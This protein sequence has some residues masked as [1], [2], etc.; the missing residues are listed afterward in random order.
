MDDKQNTEDQE[1]QTETSTSAKEDLN[2]TIKDLEYKWKRALADYHNLQKETAKEKAEFVKFANGALLMEILPVYEN[3]KTSLEHADENNHDAWLKGIKHVVKQFESILKD[4][5]VTI[6]NPVDEAF[7]PA[8]H[9][10]VEKVET[11]DKKLINKVA[12]VMKIGYKL[13]DKVIQPAKVVVY[14]HNT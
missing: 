1:K 11:D 13:H 12:R 2:E 6:I 8:E 3:L 7:N 10:A 14:T 9:E 4:N 5:G